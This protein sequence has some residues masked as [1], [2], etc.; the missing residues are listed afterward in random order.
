VD[1]ISGNEVGMKLKSQH[2]TG[3]LDLKRAHTTINAKERGTYLNT[4]I[5]LHLPL[6]SVGIKSMSCHVLLNLGIL[7]I[8]FFFFSG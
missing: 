7:S 3:G 5:C 8:K 1:R 4:K 2:C 6:L